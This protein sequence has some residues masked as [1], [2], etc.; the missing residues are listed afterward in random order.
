MRAFCRRFLE[1]KGAKMIE[2]VIFDMDGVLLDSEPYWQEAQIS[3]FGKL[4]IPLTVEDCIKTTGIAI[5]ELV[6]YRYRM[7]PWNGKTQEEAMY[8]IIHEVER[9]ILER[10]TLLPGVAE[11]INFF[12]AKGIALA[13]ASSSHIQLV[14]TVL[15][16]FGLEN[17]FRVVHS[18]EHE[19]YG[20]P[21]PAV[22]LSTA[23]RLRVE[24]ERCLV[25][26][27]SLNGLIAAKAAR[28]KALVVPPQV[29]LNDTRF[30]LA[31]CKLRSLTEFSE[32]IW[33]KLNALP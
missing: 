27:D 31:D 30:D 17:T 33:K 2:A 8:E 1:W 24:P 13:I 21:H 4:G 9:M 19:D 20:K 18:A 5:D 29:L 14:N 23:H 12:K 22:F 28:M 15:K 6:A 11:T 32:E 3:V 10:G 26:E 7:H 16:K 25:I